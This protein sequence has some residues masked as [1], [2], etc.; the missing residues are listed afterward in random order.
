[1]DAVVA[2]IRA[3]NDVAGAREALVDQFGLSVEQVSAS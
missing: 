1:M 2:G 3:A